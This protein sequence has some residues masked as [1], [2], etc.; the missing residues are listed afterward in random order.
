MFIMELT[1]SPK[2]QNNLLSSFVKPLFNVKNLEDTPQIEGT[3]QR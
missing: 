3:Q 2:E 1:L